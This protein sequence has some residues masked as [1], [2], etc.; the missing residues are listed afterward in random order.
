MFDVPT[1]VAA[2][3]DD[4]QLAR[5][6]ALVGRGFHELADGWRGPDGR[7]ASKV[8]LAA[9]LKDVDAALRRQADR[10]N[11]VFPLGPAG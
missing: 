4:R 8:K 11:E 3:T 6:R 10:K 5:C 1:W 7:K 9:A 2:K